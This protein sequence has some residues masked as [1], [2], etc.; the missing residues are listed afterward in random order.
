MT[1]RAFG[2][3]RSSGEYLGETRISVGSLGLSGMEHSV[4][5]ELDNGAMIP[6]RAARR[7]H[8]VKD[9]MLQWLW[10]SVEVDDHHARAHNVLQQ[11]FMIAHFRKLHGNRGVKFQISDGLRLSAY[12]HQGILAERSQGLLSLHVRAYSSLAK[13]GQHLLSPRRMHPSAKALERAAALEKYSG[14]LGEV[15]RVLKGLREQ[16]PSAEEKETAARE[17]MHQAQGVVQKLKNGADSKEMLG[18][19]LLREAE[20]RGGLQ[21]GDVDYAQWQIDQCQRRTLQHAAEDVLEGKT[22][23]W[24][25]ADEALKALVSKVKQTS[26]D[27]S[28]MLGHN[29]IDILDANS[30]VQE[31]AVGVITATVVCAQRLRRPGADTVSEMSCW[32]KLS[33]GDEEFETGVRTGDPSFFWNDCCRM[34]VQKGSH[35]L[36]AEILCKVPI[37]DKRDTPATL[38]ITVLQARNLIA[39]DRGGTSDPYVRLHVGDAMKESKKTKVVKKTLNPTFDET[40]RFRLSSSQRQSTLTLECFDY[41]LLGADDSLGK[42]ELDL[43][44]LV[45]EEETVRWVRLEGEEADNEGEVQVRCVLLPDLPPARLEITVLRARNLIAADRGGT[46]DPYVRVHVGESVGVGK[47][48]KVQMKTLNPEWNQSFNIFLSGSKRREDLTVEC[49]DYDM[50]GADDSLGKFQISLDSLSL[51]KEYLEW[52]RFAEEADSKNAG[53]VE[54]RYRLLRDLQGPG[55]GVVSLGSCNVALR[56]LEEGKESLKWWPVGGAG[57][58]RGILLVRVEEARDLNLNEGLP[59]CR[60]NLKTGKLSFKT[61]MCHNTGNPKWGGDP[62]SF[63]LLDTVQTLTVD[64]LRRPDNEGNEGFLGTASVDVSDVLSKLQGQESY[65]EWLSLQERFDHSGDLVSG[66]VRI[67]AAFD[68]SSSPCCGQMKLLLNYEHYKRVLPDDTRNP[69]GKCFDSFILSR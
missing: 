4:H 2:S 12:E 9:T 64:I 66:A 31:A 35:H 23:T 39:A 14:N 48:T 16:L 44:S 25:A 43:E 22:K 33:I 15:Q 21:P 7:C 62:F 36:R 30:G 26:R 63:D 38:K 65:D 13:H 27:E 11:W 45:P 57:G 56:D 20:A 61:L 68:P 1:L 49:F 19:L 50:V 37:P 55:D 28:Y 42:F 17:E 5:R 51:D 53:E 18:K 32:V 10:G 24:A 67:I 69:E 58:S 59:S 52:H 46:S 41:D 54:V 40:F 60:A 47:K 29:P 8:L 3:I 6:S 34:L